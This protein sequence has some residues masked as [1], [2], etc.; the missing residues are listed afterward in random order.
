MY[1]LFS[2]VHRKFLSV[3]YP[4]KL[5]TMKE[6]K[7][8]GHY[9]IVGIILAIV[10][11]YLEKIRKSRVEKWLKFFITVKFSRGCVLAGN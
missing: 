9:Y 5:K 10:N 8:F 2:F 1:Y 3:I 7:K 4:I 11:I 6:K